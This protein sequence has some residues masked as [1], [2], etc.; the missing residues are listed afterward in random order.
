VSSEEVGTSSGLVEPGEALD[1]WAA[2]AVDSALEVHRRL[3]PGFV[4][5]VYENALCHEL[6]LRRVPFQRQVVVPVEYKGL[7]VGEGRIDV[8][9]AS[10][11]VLELKALPELLPAHTSQIVSYLRA[12]GLS[13]GLLLNF[14]H[15]TLKAGMRRVVLTR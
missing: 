6:L 5:S 2:V 14:G 9:V 4:E 7:H 11:L 3:G 10:V 12:T 8:L 15:R 1:A 13:L